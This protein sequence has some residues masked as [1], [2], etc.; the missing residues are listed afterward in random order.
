MNLK[1]EDQEKIEALS[2]YTFIEKI[3]SNIKKSIINL[4]KG[5]GIVFLY[6]FYV[7]KKYII[8]I[9]FL[10]TLGISAGSYFLYKNG[11]TYYSSFIAKTSFNSGRILYKLFTDISDLVNRKEFEQVSKILNIPLEDA[12]KL[13]GFDLQKISN[14][15]EEARLYRQY[16]YEVDTNYY[17]PIDRKDYLKKLATNEYYYQTVIIYSAGKINYKLIQDRLIE[18]INKNEH[19]TTQKESYIES[20]QNQIKRYEQNNKNLDSLL[21]AKIAYLTNKNGE[22]KNSESNLIIGEN[23]KLSGNNEEWIFD[24]SFGNQVEIGKLKNFIYETETV[25]KAITDVNG[26]V[27]DSNLKGI[28]NW[29]LKGFLFG[30]ILS[31]GWELLQ[32]LNKKQKSIFN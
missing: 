5:T 16:L 13:Y 30:L 22:Q 14:E 21:V 18:Y 26:G 12:K 24:K 20:V 32:F 3:F 4:F 27:K 7:I 10:T 15:I 6:F 9:G 17:K 2:F 29:A 11:P 31:L 1:H 8:I 28:L 19:L 23:T 25:A